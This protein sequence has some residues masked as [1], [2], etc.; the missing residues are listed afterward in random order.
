MAPL[1]EAERH[2]INTSLRIIVGERMGEFGHSL[3]LTLSE[4]LDQ[5]A[6]RISDLKDVSVGLSR[7]LRD[8]KRSREPQ[9]Q[10]AS[11][12][13]LLTQAIVC[14]L[15]GMAH[16]RLPE[17]VAAK[18]YAS[19]R[20]I[21]EAVAS[22]SRVITRTAIGPAMTTVPSWAAELVGIGNHSAIA[23]LAPDS[24]YARLSARGQRV[25]FAHVG[26][27]RVPAPMAQSD[28]GGVFVAE[29]E[30]IVVKRMNLAGVTLSPRKAAVISHF[31]AETFEASTP[32]IETVVKQAIADDTGSEVDGVLLDDGAADAIRPAGLL[33]G[34]TPLPPTPNGGIEALSGDIRQLAD[35]VT[36]T[37]PLIDP[38]LIVDTASEIAIRLLA[39]VPPLPVIGAATVPARTAILV[40]AADF[41]SAEGD[42]LNFDASR[43]ALLH[44]ETVPLAISAGG[45][46]ASPSRSLWQTDCI[47]LRMLQS[48]DWALR[49][50]GRVAVV[51]SITW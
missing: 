46:M 23:A 10:A 36:A 2:D 39:P 7:G 37:G 28:V 44:E 45:T 49:R 14:Q 51:E 3:D 8:L 34:L 25:S 41:C 33:V 29:G 24:V 35:A 12:R 22:P 6:K 31:T 48:L 9:Q 13:T 19:N 5:I 27:V 32:N 18:D 47:A 26:Q 21:L 20:N 15:V 17:E 38:V 43:E 16:N 42:D 4:R 50:P 40:D 30:P 11:L 1:S